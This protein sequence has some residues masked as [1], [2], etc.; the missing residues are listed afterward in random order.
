M[1]QRTVIAVAM[2]VTAGW[3]LG[4]PRSRAAQNSPPQNGQQ[5]TRQ[6]MAPPL[7]PRTQE[8]GAQAPSWIPL[9]PDHARY[10]DDVLRYWEYRSA[11]VERYRCRFDRC[12]YDP[13]QGGEFP[14][15]WA[16]GV[17]KYAAPDKGLFQVEE[18]K[19]L[20]P[21]QK[22]GESPRYEPLEGVLGEHWIC[23]GKSIFEFDEH[24]K[25]LIQREL[26]PEMQ[27]RHIVEG[28]LPFM[29]GAKAETI[30]QRYWMRV[31]VPPP[32]KDAYW[33]EAVPRTRD[34]AADFK[35]LHIVIAEKDYL[36]EGMILYHR[37]GAKTTFQFSQREV[38]WNDLI[39]RLTPFHQEFYEPAT[40]PGWKKIVD[41]YSPPATVPV[42]LPARGAVRESQLPQRFSPR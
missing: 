22:Q 9:P 41:K 1:R 13:V 15:T 25:Q 34:D 23:D 10:L 6:M 18:V 32:K 11:K 17:I 31:I 7:A 5:S 40:P 42:A 21:P 35:L 20:V 28:P 38:N 19:Q 3:M 36:P 8:P 26:P 29:F 24:K 4:L 39:E 2:V 14:K 30:Q 12:E 16:R 33:L 37:N 27:G